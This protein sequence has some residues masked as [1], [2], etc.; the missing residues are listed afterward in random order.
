MPIEVGSG[1]SMLKI[2]LVFLLGS[3][4]CSPPT[5]VSATLTA[6]ALCACVMLVALGNS[7]ARAAHIHAPFDTELCKVN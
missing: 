7:G 2:L 4:P 3:I 6:A 1:A 5:M